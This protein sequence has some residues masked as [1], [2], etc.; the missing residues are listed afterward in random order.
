MLDNIVLELI[1]KET[2]S[3]A[4]MARLCARVQKRRPMAPFNGFGKRQPSDRPPVLTPAEKDALKAH[5]RGRRRRAQNGADG[6]GHGA[7]VGTA[8]GDAAVEARPATSR[9]ER[10]SAPTRRLDDRRRRPASW[11]ISPRGWSTAG[12]AAAPS[13]RRVDLARIEQAVREILIAVGEDPDRDGLRHTPAR[14]ARAYAELFAGLRVDADEVLTTTFEADHE[15]LV[16]VRDI[17]VMSMLRA[18]PA[19]VPR[20]RPRRLHPRPGRPDHR[21]VQAGPAGRGVRPPPPGAGAADLADRRHP[22]GAAWSPR[23]VIVVIECEH[24]CMA[25]RGIQKPGARTITSAVRGHLPARRQVPGRGDEP[26]PRPRLTRTAWHLVTPR[27]FGVPLDAVFDD[28]QHADSGA[29]QQVGD[30]RRRSRPAGACARPAAPPGA[31]R[32][33]T[34]IVR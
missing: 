14:V 33:A 7:D 28:E 26:D 30:Q 22:H 34:P 3:Q 10:P 15:E 29:Q 27:R 5:R 21:A 31:G 11:T 18:P 1:E 25:M 8:G 13:S 17:E 32:N 12:W 4:D 2:I 23:G 9:A 19:A 20:R 6:D 24:M 16:L